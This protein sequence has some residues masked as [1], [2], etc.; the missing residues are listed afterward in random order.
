[1]K[2]RHMFAA[3][4]ALGLS[5]LIAAPSFAADPAAAVVANY[6]AAWNTHDAAKAAEY[7]APE[8]SYFDASVG[9]PVVGKDA[10]KAGVIDNF[11][12]AAPDLKWEMKGEPVV[13]GDKVAFE[14]KFSGTNKGAWADGTA[15]TNKPFA[16]DGAS[17][18]EVKDGLITH[19]ADYYDALGFYKQL[20]LM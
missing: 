8:V 3:A 1:M 15:A 13:S 2:R 6:L 7:F 9:T 5:M 16:F 4:G 14:W 10:A 19:Q 12:N 18:F 11:M 17:V 20:G